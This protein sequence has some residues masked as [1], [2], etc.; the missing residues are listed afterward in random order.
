MRQCYETITRWI[1]CSQ[2]QGPVSHD[3]RTDARRGGT[4]AT[5]EQSDG[6]QSPSEPRP[7]HDRATAGRRPNDGAIA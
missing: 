1:V 2:S 4:A 6:D 3:G 7:G 5:E